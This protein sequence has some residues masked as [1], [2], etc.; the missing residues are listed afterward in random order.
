MG[1]LRRQNTFFMLC[2]VVVDGVRLAVL[3]TV[4]LSHERGTSHTALPS[5]IS[6][7]A[8]GVYSRASSSASAKNGFKHLRR[9]Y[10][11]RAISTTSSHRRSNLLQSIGWIDGYGFLKVLASGNDYEVV[12]YLQIPIFGMWIPR[13]NDMQCFRYLGGNLGVVASLAGKPIMILA[14]PSLELFV[15]AYRVSKIRKFCPSPARCG[16]PWSC[17]KAR[18]R[19]PERSGCIKIRL[20]PRP[21]A[22][23]TVKRLTHHIRLL[24]AIA[25]SVSKFRL[26]HER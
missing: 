23:H 5:Y 6:M 15:L 24:S 2:R 16:V 17:R 25:S 13:G 7:K 14:G 8:H 21:P 9:E 20:F 4:G 22:V 18:Y 12:V 10:L 11:T 1:G 3:K 19:L 26:Y